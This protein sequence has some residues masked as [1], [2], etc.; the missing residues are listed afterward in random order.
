MGREKTT[1]TVVQ[2]QTTTPT[3]TAEEKEL[4]K[5]DLEARRG[6]QEGIISSQKA[7]LDLVT[8]LL[9]GSTDLPGFFKT[10]EAGISPEV[11]SDIVQNSLRDL[12]VQ[13]AKSG[14]G[15]FAD[16][17]ASF[18]SGVRTAGDIRRVS[19]EF[20]IGNR[21]NLLN[22]ALSGQAQ[23]QA[24]VLGMAS[25]LGGRLAG[26]RSVNQFGNST[27]TTLGMNPFMK[28]FQQTLGQTLGAPQT[29][30][31]GGKPSGVTFGA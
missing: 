2:N 22:L 12:N 23:V 11:T 27:G 9:Q 4:I 31:G 15:T 1:E 13:L 16:S 30:F 29:S 17:G 26:L 25:S 18:S 7:G 28:S 6:T 21:L 8:K 14:A 24:P 20:N 10:L 5:L 3:P 19:E